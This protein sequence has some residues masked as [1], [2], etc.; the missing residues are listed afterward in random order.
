MDQSVSR[1]AAVV[2]SCGFETFFS[3]FRVHTVLLV[4]FVSIIFVE[5]IDTQ[6]YDRNISY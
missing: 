5:K 1:Q 2:R 6:V 4:T 3:T